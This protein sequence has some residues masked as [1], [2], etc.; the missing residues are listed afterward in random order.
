[1]RFLDLPPIWLV[2]FLAVTWM[3]PWI[4]PW[5]PMSIAGLLIIATGFL[6]TVAAL[7]EFRRARTT[8]I[9][10]QSPD[11][12]ITS[13]IFRYSRNP[14]YLSDVL[15][16]LGFALMWGKLVGI[17]LVPVFAWMLERRF[18]RGEEARLRDAFGEEFIA[19]SAR[20]RRWI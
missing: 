1:M 2:L 8:V 20:T 11:A 16:L 13:G 15:I 4:V 19:Y 6:M 9:P 18:I 17:A 10:R 5:G 12:L 14:I 7:V 3:S